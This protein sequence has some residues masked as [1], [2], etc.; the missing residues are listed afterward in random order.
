MGF[1]FFLFFPFACSPFFAVMK[2]MSYGIC[3]KRVRPHWLVG[4]SPR[5]RAVVV[6]GNARAK[7]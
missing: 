2:K 1:F 5:A 7:Y 3:S 4:G 6:M